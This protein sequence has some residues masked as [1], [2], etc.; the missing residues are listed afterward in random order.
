[1]DSA[2]QLYPDLPLEHVQERIRQIKSKLGERLLILAH[3]YQLD[4]V[5]ELADIK[6]DSLKLARLSSDNK[7]AEFIVFCGVYF[8]AEVASALANSRQKIILP[9]LEAGCFLA[10]CATI[11]A[12]EDFWQQ[13]KKRRSKKK[14]IPIVYINSSAEIKAFCGRNDGAVCTSGNAESIIKWGLEHAEMVLFLPDQ[15]LGRNIAYKMGLSA[16]N[17]ITISKENPTE[18]IDSIK[19]S[20]KILLWPGYCDIHQEFT[21]EDIRTVRT[22]YKGIKII[23]HPEC[24]YEVVQESDYIGSTEKIIK[25]IEDAEEGSVWAVGTERELVNR[26][27]KRWF[28]IKRVINLSEKEPYCKTMKMI[29]ARKLLWV[30]ENIEKDKIVN[31]IK[32]DQKIKEESLIALRRMLEIT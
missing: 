15:N 21:L 19:D 13:L 31:E 32:V 27:S 9:D 5:Y 24:P 2:N 25:T 11:D 7:N 23:V 10:D 26:L 29:D 17:M 4:E 28:G 6:G 8:M 16:D 22:K 14:I 18:S 1:M 30:L 3:H 12:V 20:T